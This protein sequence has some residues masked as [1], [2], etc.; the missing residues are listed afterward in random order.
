LQNTL[1]EEI[2]SIDSVAKK[3]SHLYCS[4]DSPMYKK[5]IDSNGI[6]DLRN[7]LNDCYHQ[8]RR[9][10]MTER[11]YN[12][13]LNTPEEQIF[14][15][16]ELEDKELYNAREEEQREIPKASKPII[17]SEPKTLTLKPQPKRETT[18][19]PLVDIKNMLEN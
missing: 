5:G 4:G 10:T 16:L 8:I 6:I 12:Y 9:R 1:E 3:L 17:L 14:L 2:G 15:R 13:F 11:E 18:R 7:K 19:I